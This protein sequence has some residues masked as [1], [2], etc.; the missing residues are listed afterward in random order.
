[1]EDPATGEVAVVQ[2]AHG[3]VELELE[4]GVEIDLW[5]VAPFGKLGCTLDRS[6]RATDASTLMS[7]AG[8]GR[9]AGLVAEN[10]CAREDVVGVVR[11]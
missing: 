5:G 2:G 4:L 7:P 10:G 9:L 6:E 11:V 1:M 8:T 3:G